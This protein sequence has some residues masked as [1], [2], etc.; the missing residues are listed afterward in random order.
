MEQLRSICESFGWKNVTSYIQSGNILFHSDTSETDQMADWLY[1]HLLDAFHFEVAVLVIPLQD[2]REMVANN[3]FS[4]DSAMEE[5]FQHI[6]FLEKKPL[7]EKG[8]V[9]NEMDFSPEKWAIVDR[10]VYLFCPNGYGKS[11]L[12]NS[13][14]ERKLG[15]RATT[16]N[17]RTVTELLSI[18][19]KMEPNR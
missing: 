9:L 2:Y 4:K 12:T 3:P 11:K 18:A 13:F 5:Q 6:T 16:R 14:L 19:E 1:Q 17:W 7:P 10:A 15:V 8:N